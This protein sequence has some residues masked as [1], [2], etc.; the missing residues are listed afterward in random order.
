MTVFLCAPF[1]SRVKGL[2]EEGED[3]GNTS[4]FENFFFCGTD[5]S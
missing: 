2:S 5:W 1:L 3:C 4:G